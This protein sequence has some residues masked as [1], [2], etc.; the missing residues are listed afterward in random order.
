MY[1]SPKT[2]E[3]DDVTIPVYIY[4][5]ILFLPVSGGGLVL[6]KDPLSALVLASKDIKAYS[7]LQGVLKGGSINFKKEFNFSPTHMVLDIVFFF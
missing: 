2:L 3:L 7:Q 4:I 6:G 1:N 5:Y